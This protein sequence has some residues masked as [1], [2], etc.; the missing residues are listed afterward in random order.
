MVY[1]MGGAMR[2]A[3]GVG[4][5]ERNIVAA[6]DTTAIAPPTKHQRC[7]PRRRALPLAM[8]TESA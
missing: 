1:A 5:L 7:N 8:F 4:A 2:E 3:P 6:I